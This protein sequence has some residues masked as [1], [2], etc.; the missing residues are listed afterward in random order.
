[1]TFKK[2]ELTNDLKQLI[3]KKDKILTAVDIDD[4]RYEALRQKQ[5]QGMTTL[6]ENEQI[7][8]HYYKSMLVVDTLEEKPLKPFVFNNELIYNFKCLVDDKNI[9][10][11]ENFRTREHIHKTTIVK[12]FLVDKNRFIIFLN[13]LLMIK[14]KIRLIL[15]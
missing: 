1:M 15:R 10:Q 14:T 4:I 8:K 11:R 6:A 13:W 12:V 9:K 5:K 7:Q 3:F 2:K